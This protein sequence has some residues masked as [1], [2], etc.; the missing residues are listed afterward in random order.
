M[1]PADLVPRQVHAYSAHCVFPLESHATSGKKLG[2][3]GNNSFSI[4]RLECEKR[5]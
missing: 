4:P 5:C 2:S 1:G 3:A